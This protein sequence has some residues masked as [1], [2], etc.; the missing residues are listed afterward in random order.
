MELLPEFEAG[1]LTDAGTR[2]RNWGPSLRRLEIARQWARSPV[3]DVGAG[4]G[5][6]SLHLKH[7]GFDVT[8]SDYLDESLAN[9]ND[10]L[11][12]AGL[13]IPISRQD[14]TNLS[15]EDDQFAS[16]FCISVL[17]YVPD[18][19]A[20]VAELGR[21]LRPG[22]IAVLGA[23]NGYG[24]Y[25]FINDR[26]PRTLFRS[27][28]DRGGRYPHPHHL[29]GPRWWQRRLGQDFNVIEIMPVE[30]FSPA[31]A[32]FLGYEAAEPWTHRDSRLAARMPKELA[33]EVLYVVR[34]PEAGG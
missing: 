29:H 1:Q 3:L 18:L 23:I 32:R 31:L 28:R 20:A 16:L 4:T 5:W 33:S 30:A 10:N 6:L 11:Q 7:W 15:Y 12:V 13:Q 21:V 17:P 26:D 25:A 8:A 22:G 14:V 34:A 2:I 9:F 27:T 24:A 19:D